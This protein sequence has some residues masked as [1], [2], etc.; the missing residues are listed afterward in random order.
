MHFRVVTEVAADPQ[1]CFDV[2]RDIDVHVDSMGSSGEQAVAGVRHGLIDLDE[3]VTFEAR[4]LG[5]RWRMTSRITEF[6]RPHQF[7]DEMQKGPFGS[8]R[9]EHRYEATARGTRMIDEVS[10]R[11]PAG[12]V[13]RAV[14]RLFLRRYMIRLITERAEHLRTVAEG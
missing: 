7:V 8:W 1:R 10:Y 3:E 13:G 11:S 2:S 9:H 6:D 12:I 14:D 4:H 5:L